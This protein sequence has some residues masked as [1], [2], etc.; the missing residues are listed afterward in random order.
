MA[1]F[2]HSSAVGQGGGAAAKG[3]ELAAWERRFL[4]KAWLICM[5]SMACVALAIPVFLNAIVSDPETATARYMQFAAAIF[6]FANKAVQLVQSVTHPRALLRWKDFCVLFDI[7]LCIPVALGIQ[8]V[9]PWPPD[10]VHNPLFEFLFIMLMLTIY[11]VPFRPAVITI[12]I[13]VR[14]S[15]PAA[16]CSA[17]HALLACAV[18]SGVVLALACI[19]SCRN[20]PRDPSVAA[21]RCVSLSVLT[22]CCCESAGAWVSSDAFCFLYPTSP[23]RRLSTCSVT[24]TRGCLAGK[25]RARPT[26]CPAASSFASWH[27]RC[28]SLFTCR[29]SA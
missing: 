10:Q 7:N 17:M 23:C 12:I 15:P 20:A 19:I 13:Q 16:S 26:T 9:Y 4:W 5:P 3:T 27:T 11:Q 24:T 2:V 14:C 6:I 22:R 25:C 1:G 28:P 21:S 18:L 29:W 8:Y